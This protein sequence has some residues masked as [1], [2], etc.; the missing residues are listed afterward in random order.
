MQI[1]SIA[2]V[3]E[4]RFF[5]GMG[6]FLAYT[7]RCNAKKDNFENDVPGEVYSNL[8][9]EGYEASD[10]KQVW[11]MRNFLLPH[12]RKGASSSRRK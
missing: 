1:E 3:M 12:P 7:G 8:P 4:G 9:G 2:A 10:G 11:R 5:S 6:D